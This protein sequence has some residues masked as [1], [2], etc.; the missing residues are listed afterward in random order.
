LVP[1]GKQAVVGG[2]EPVGVSGNVN[3]VEIRTV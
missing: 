2:G 1:P 3:L